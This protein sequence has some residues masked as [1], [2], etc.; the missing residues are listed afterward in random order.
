MVAV[1][2]LVLM[3]LR[4]V[5]RWFQPALIALVAVGI[6]Y[7]LAV[8][9]FCPWYFAGYGAAAERPWAWTETHGAPSRTMEE[10]Q[11]I[12]FAIGLILWASLRRRMRVEAVVVCLLAAAT[13]ALLAPPPATRRAAGLPLLVS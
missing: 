8:R 6:F 3:R 7:L 13:G 11:I 9:I 4:S 12:R 2:L 10:K 1:E 5:R